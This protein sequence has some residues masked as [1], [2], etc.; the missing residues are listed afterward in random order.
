M[1]GPQTRYFLMAVLF[2]LASLPAHAAV[3]N[4]DTSSPDNIPGLTGFQTHG[5]DM[6]G[7]EVTATF[8]LASSETLSWTDTGTDAGGVFGDGWSLT[9]SGDSFSS[10]SWVF[11]ITGDLL[12]TGLQLN[13][14]PGLTVFDKTNPSFGTDGSAQGRDFATDLTG[15]GNVVATYSDPVGVG[16]ADP[17]GDLFH[18]LTVD[19]TG[20]D[21]GGTRSGFLMSQDTDN[22]SRLTQVPLPGTLALLA[23]GLLGLGATSRRRG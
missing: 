18:T 7:M 16:G 22:D 15:D 6:V 20:L 9:L 1:K 21:A 17:V 8:G 23:L 10:L 2:G 4:T 13:G 19:F 11:S 14:I 12:L 3:I 5:D